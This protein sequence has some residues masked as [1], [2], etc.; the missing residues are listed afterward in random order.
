LRPVFCGSFFGWF[1]LPV[2]DKSKNE[3]PV[4]LPLMKF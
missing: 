1:H 4:P 3:F 2:P